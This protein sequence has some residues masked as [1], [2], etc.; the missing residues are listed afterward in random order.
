MKRY[1]RAAAL[2]VLCLGMQACASITTG[3][4]QSVVVDTTP[5]QQATC[6]MQNEKGQWTVI[7]TPGAA[8]VS[9]AYGLLSVQCRTEAGHTGSSSV[10]STTAGAAFG[11][12]IAGGLVGAAVDIGSGAAYQYPAQVLVS[13][14][15]PAGSPAT[16]GA[17]VAA[18]PAPA[19]PLVLCRQRKIEEYRD[20][21]WCRE[22]RGK[23]IHIG[24][25]PQPATGAITS[26]TPP[27]AGGSSFSTAPP[28]ASG[29]VPA[30]MGARSH[31]RRKRAWR[32]RGLSGPDR[33]TG[34]SSAD[35]VSHCPADCSGRGERAWRVLRF[36][37]RFPDDRAIIK[38]ETPVRSPAAGEEISTRTL[39]V[40][41]G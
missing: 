24:P 32:R 1:I 37:T 7:R 16:V 17:L 31:R 30:P 28:V 35:N 21:T 11:N 26:V 2:L 27:T 14:S 4:T 18:P 23:A 29:L 40:R 34:L 38:P 15:S 5:V 3:T 33:A 19:Q 9:K 13:L 25:P 41:A 20:E 10:N 36:P 12:I 8:T 22:A 39:P 6:T